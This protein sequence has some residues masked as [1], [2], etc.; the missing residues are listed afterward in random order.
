MLIAFVMEGNFMLN[1]E[2]KYV[3]VTMKVKKLFVILTKKC[4]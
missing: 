2:R 1:S 3:S 4:K